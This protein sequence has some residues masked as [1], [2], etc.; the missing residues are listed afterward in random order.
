MTHSSR[1][2]WPLFYRA[3]ID[4]MQ[5]RRLTVASTSRSSWAA[6]PPGPIVQAGLGMRSGKQSRTLDCRRSVHGSEVPDLRGGST[7]KRPLFP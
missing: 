1:I 2:L 7:G 3:E 4:P 5:R 6:G